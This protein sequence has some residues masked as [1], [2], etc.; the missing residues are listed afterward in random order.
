MQSP[1]HLFTS[2]ES[3]RL[4]QLSDQRSLAVYDSFSAAVKDSEKFLSIAGRSSQ[5]TSANILP[6]G[7]EA[8]KG[9]DDNP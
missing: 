8:P 1:A 3:S 6:H 4:R 9:A 5:I 7:L 2:L